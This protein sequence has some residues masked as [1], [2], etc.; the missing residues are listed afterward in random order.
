MD[1]KEYINI[2]KYDSDSELRRGAAISLIET[3]IYNSDIINAFIQGILDKDYGLKDICYRALSNPPLEF[4]EQIAEHIAYFITSNEIELRNLAG[5]ILLKIGKA[6]EIPL[7]TYLQFDNDDVKQFAADIIGAIGTE[8]SITAF[9]NLLQEN[10]PNIVAS[11]IDGLGKLKAIESVKYFL[12]LYEKNEDF[13]PIIIEALGKIGGD[14]AQDFIISKFFSEEDFFIQTA[15]LEA[16]AQISDRIFI[17]DKLMQEITSFPE[18]IQPIILKTIF[19]IS[20]RN[21]IKP[22]LPLEYRSIARK[23]LFDEDA[24]T[25]A[26]GLIALGDSF[27]IEDIT[28]LL[29]EIRYDRVDSQ[30]QILFNILANSD[31]T[32]VDKFFISLF[33]QKKPIVSYIE[34]LSLLPLFVDYARQ[35][36]IDRLIKTMVRL[37]V[38]LGK[39]NSDSIL[40]IL[41]SIN[42]SKTI[43]ELIT[44]SLNGSEEEK[45]EIREIAERLFLNELL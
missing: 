23:A 25:R 33:Y 24:D 37:I 18:E 26:A 34:F 22:E 20:F 35:E 30:K 42:Y 3:G 11:A 12:P 6:S 21:N 2:L 40:E 1:I 14:E 36:N 4:A 32:V 13:K 7:L 10:N 17:V 43:E 39:G 29:N 28:A 19:A 5:D 15:C 38:I 41:L 27:F 16:L 31:A 45:Q 9:I 44:Y 8:K